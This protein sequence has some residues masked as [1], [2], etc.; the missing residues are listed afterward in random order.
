MITS[1]KSISKWNYWLQL[2]ALVA[3]FLT[4][5]VPNMLAQQLA[6]IGL[7]F[8][9]IIQN[10]EKRSMPILDPDGTPHYVATEVTPSKKEQN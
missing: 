6:T 1:S 8:S 9:L 2:V 10:L 3:L 5:A 4:V 7:F